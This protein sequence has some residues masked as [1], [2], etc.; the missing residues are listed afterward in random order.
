MSF[1]EQRF[2]SAAILRRS[3][4]AN[5]R[6]SGDQPPERRSPGHRPK[7]PAGGGPFIGKAEAARPATLPFARRLRRGLIVGD[8]EIALP[9][10]G[11]SAARF[12]K[13]VLCLALFS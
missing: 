1:P 10:A 4:L 8:L 2:W 3:G 7:H 6:P 12:C 9:W 5:K 11:S 13:A